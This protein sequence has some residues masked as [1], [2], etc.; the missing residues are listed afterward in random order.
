MI[1]RLF[2]SSKYTKGVKRAGLEKI[3]L[4]G[5][6][7]ERVDESVDSMEISF[8][9]IKTLPHEVQNRRPHATRGVTRNCKSKISHHG[10]KKDKKANN[11]RNNNTQ[12]AKD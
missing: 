9:G 3:A 6:H 7:S 12:K 4:V 10:Q 5:R 11:G 8:S 1:F 2:Y